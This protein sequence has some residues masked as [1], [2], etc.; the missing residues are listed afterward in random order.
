MRRLLALLLLAALAPSAPTVHADQSAGT[1]VV[2]DWPGNGV[3]IAS[4]V[5]VL[6]WAVS[7]EASR[8]T[9]VDA[10]SA[11][12]DGPADVGTSLGRAA[13]GQV[14]PD[15][16]LAQGDG[17]Y[18]PSG[19]SLR[20]DLPPGARTLFV[21]AHLADR[22]ADEGWVG[23]WQIALQ[24]DGGP[25]VASPTPR[26]GPATPLGPGAAM[27]SAREGQPTGIGGG[28]ACLDRE[29]G[30]GRCLSFGGSN[31]GACAVPDPDSGRCLVRPSTA[32]P[33]N[34]G[35]AGGAVRGSWSAYSL[36]ASSSA[37][38]R[39]GAAESSLSGA[40]SQPGAQVSGPLG[41]GLGS[42]VS[43]GSGGGSGASGGGSGA[44]GASSGGGASGSGNATG[45][46]A[47]AG[48]GGGGP[49]LASVA[50]NAAAGTRSSA[51]TRGAGGS[52]G[53]SMGGS[54]PNASGSPNLLSLST[55]QVSPN[56]ARLT[57]NQVGG[58]A[59][60]YEVRRCSSLNSPTIAC[61]VVAIVQ[62]GSYLVTVG[63]GTYLVRAVGPL[64]EVQGE[65]N[66]VQICCGG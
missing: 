38:S 20:A 59:G 15:V 18:G 21:Y 11:Y 33:G 65:S 60:G 44:S 9:G 31:Y 5:T 57:W 46:S 45:P 37:S 4:P 63:Q 41:Y 51:V 62:A 16:A 48:W 24:I 6:G 10:V 8:G 17:R 54:S 47:Q 66:R 26:E 13:Y 27:P 50:P 25:T 19:W 40:L 56:Q 39:G 23:P 43:Q 3:A 49:A 12:V 35:P 36:L 2:V 52:P 64:G 34:G 7:A 29:Q 28:G 61:T 22:P 30:S 58:G 32:N 1:T 53:T 42:L 14:R 55:T